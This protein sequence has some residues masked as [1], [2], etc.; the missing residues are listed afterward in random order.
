MNVWMI[1]ITKS[2]SEQHGYELTPAS[3]GVRL[4]I[5]TQGQAPGLPRVGSAVSQLVDGGQ[6]SSA[7][8][9][10]HFTAA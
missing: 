8:A 4:W 5:R 1:L 7:R 2:S 3:A 9:E 6:I 10:A